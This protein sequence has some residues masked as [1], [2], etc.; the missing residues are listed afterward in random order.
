MILPVPI[1]AR[2]AHLALDDRGYPIPFFAPIINGKPHFK[3]IDPKILMIAVK[4]KL[5]HICGHSLPKDSFFFISGPN[6]LKNRISSDMAMHRECAEFSLAACP[7][8]AF[9]S[10]DRKI[11]TVGTA[12]IAEKPSIIYLVKANKL[13]AI[14]DPTTGGKTFLIKYTPV[15]AKQ[16]IYVNKKLTATDKP[17]MKFL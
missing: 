13:K 17:D 10:A 12:I 8:L 14:P 1:P 11:Q 2:M 3:E 9:E 7:Y 15:S 5:C 4:K 16:Y 6:G